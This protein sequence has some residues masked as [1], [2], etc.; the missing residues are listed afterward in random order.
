MT[1]KDF[2]VTRKS[3]G[4]SGAEIYEGSLTRGIAETI[5]C[6]KINEPTPMSIY[7]MLDDFW[8]KSEIGKTHT[9]ETPKVSHFA[10]DRGKTG[11]S[12]ARIAITVINIM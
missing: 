10:S 6:E 9:K 8:F 4:N 3:L 2:F 5:P 1:G 7:T 11:K 12:T